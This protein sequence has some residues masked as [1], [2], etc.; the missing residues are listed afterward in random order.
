[1]FGFCSSS[2][3][4]VCVVFLLGP[5]FGQPP[6]PNGAGSE[7]LEPLVPPIISAVPSPERPPRQIGSIGDG[8]VPTASPVPTKASA[9]CRNLICRTLSGQCTSPVNSI[10]GQARFAQFSYIKNSS[11]DVP[12]GQ[13]LKSSRE[14]SNIVFRQ[15]ANTVNSHGL[16]ELFTYFGL[17]LDHNLAATPLN[18]PDRMDIV[19]PPSDPH[20]S[21]ATISFSRSMRGLTGIGNNRRAINA[22][23]SAVDL[24]GVYGTNDLRNTALL[25]NDRFGGLTGRMKTSG[26]NLMPLNSVNAFNAPDPS[27]RFF[28]AGDS[29][30][31]ENPILTAMHT[32]FLREHNHF[33]ELVK[34]R[35]P[36][37]PPRDVYEYAR[38]LNIAQFQKIVYEEFYPAILRRGLAPYRGFKRVNPTVSDLFAGAAFRFGHTLVGMNLPRR[39]PSGPLPPLE[40]ADA[41]FRPASTFSSAELDNLLRGVANSFAQEADVQVVDLI[42]NFLFTPVKG[43]PTLDLI[44]FDIQRGRDHALPKFNEIRALLGI[45]KATS[46]Q[47]ITR[48]PN[49]V[50]LLQKA[51]DN[52]IDDVEAFVGMLAEDRIPGSGMGRTVAAVWREEFT[53]LR[54]GDQFFYLNT[55]KLPSLLRARFRD[56]EQMLLRRSLDTFRQVLTRNSNLTVADLPTGNV[57]QIRG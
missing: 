54:D 49:V 34:Q 36:S 47:S 19:V 4:F 10:W 31:N 46:F 17:F 53:R 11:S 57:F 56:F 3:L 37:L 50:E 35:I 24:G 21:V 43:Q 55:R 51:Y 20:L 42:R 9:A 33:A 29:R 27:D 23:T 6:I 48:D 12:T 22:M 32:I 28:L 8:T 30:S 40:T 15:T 45:T 5:T 52:S 38:K 44:S 18:M 7:A 14:I 2:V 25:E 13:E 26:D 39:G 16:N 41:F 1:M